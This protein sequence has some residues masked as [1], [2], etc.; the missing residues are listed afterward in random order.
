MNRR[1]FIKKSALASGVVFVPQFV[2]ALEPLATN[3]WSKKKLVII[4]LSG[5]ND[6]LN[7][8]IPF[9]NDIYYQKRPQLAI[10]KN[11]V[12][13]L[14]DSLGFH[15]S[16]KAFEKLFKNGE[17]TIINNVG[18]PN[19]NRSHFRS[20][21][22]WHTASDSNKYLNTG[23]LGRYLDVYGNKPYSGIEVDDSLSLMMKGKIRKG[24][25]T[26]NPENLKRFS[27]A[28][29]FKKVLKE[30]NNEHLSE[31]NLGYLYKTL[32]ETKSSAN[33]I[34]KTSKKYSSNVDYPNNPFAK[35]LQCIGQLINAGLDTDVFYASMGGF[36]THVY[37]IKK[38]ERLL[39][40]MSESVH[41]FVDDLKKG[42]S[43]E[44]TVVMIF[45]EFGRRVAQNA[46]NG[47]D[48]GAANNVYI[49]GKD[50]KSPGFL[51]NGPNLS[52]LDNNKDLQY[53]IDFRAIYAS[54]MNNWMQCDYT[55][56]ISN[57]F[58]LLP[59]V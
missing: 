20:T 38:Q 8:V 11:K 33:H 56:L 48:H 44:N 59:L 28:P 50:L 19:P 57:K 17:M 3:R 55:Q 41:A 1:D 40:I 9:D 13:R 27:S 24:I 58:E 15:P 45:S 31:H 30:H 37:Q 39:S 14:N 12:L 26:K 43:F 16:M 47:T 32:I 42:K 25:A 29:F 53:E 23:F 10:P 52:S 22:I 4:Q 21:D 2:K 18:Y 6:G 5:G 7:T 34:Y 35:Q 51:N 46:A 36:D 54:L 49:I